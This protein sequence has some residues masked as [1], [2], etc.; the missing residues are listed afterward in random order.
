MHAENSLDVKGRIHRG[1]NAKFNES[2]VLNER[3]GL[4]KGASNKWEVLVARTENETYKMVNHHPGRAT[5]LEPYTMSGKKAVS[6][7]MA[8]VEETR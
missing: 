8:M 4:N 3:A 1:V 6:M 5:S 7:T 2:T